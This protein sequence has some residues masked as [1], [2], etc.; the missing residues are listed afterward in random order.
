MHTFS[1]SF[2]KVVF[3]VA[4]LNFAYFWVEYDVAIQIGSVSLFADS[5]DF[6]EDT[7]INILILVAIGWSAHRRSQVGFLLAGIS[8]KGSHAPKLPLKLQI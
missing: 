4:L 6:L 7:A 3:L 8:F 5:I 1:S 2:K